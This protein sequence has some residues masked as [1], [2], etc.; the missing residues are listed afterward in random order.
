MGSI[1]AT[2]W[3][4]NNQHWPVAPDRDPFGLVGHGLVSQ[5]AHETSWASFFAYSAGPQIKQVA[6][7]STLLTRW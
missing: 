3:Q 7:W 5:G 2:P 4:F 1:T 6:C